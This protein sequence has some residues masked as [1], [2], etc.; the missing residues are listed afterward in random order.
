MTKNNKAFTDM[1]GLRAAGFWPNGKAPSVRTLRDWTRLRLL[2]YHKVG[3][4]VFYDVDEVEEF[5]RT[6]LKI[7]PRVVA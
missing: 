6:R 1:N 5:I 7:T 2:P 4:F 3:H